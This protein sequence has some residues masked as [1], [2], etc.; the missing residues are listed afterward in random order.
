VGR[1]V[2][3][4]THAHENFRMELFTVPSKDSETPPSTGAHASLRQLRPRERA[5]VTLQNSAPSLFFF[6]ER[7]YTVE[8]AYG[9]WRDSGSWWSAS[10]W[11]FEQWDL[12][13]RAQDGALL[14]CCL[15]RDLMR[16]EWQM[17]ALYD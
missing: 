10:L 7:R 5:S 1:A 15:I 3:E 17:A 6:R 16:N 4:D 13:A 9:P 8:R 2:L 14:C 12:V 11:G